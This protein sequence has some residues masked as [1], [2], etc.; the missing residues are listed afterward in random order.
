[1]AVLAVRFWPAA[2]AKFS[3]S[4]GISLAFG[5]ILFLLALL[6]GIYLAECLVWARPGAVVLATSFQAG[7]FRLRV[8]HAW[9]LLRN[10]HG[11]L[12]LGFAQ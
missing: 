6:A 11:G 3:L 10:D 1:M 4:F 5:Q 12:V 9:A 7:R 8:P 2:P